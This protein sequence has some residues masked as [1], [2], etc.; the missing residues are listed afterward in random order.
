[1]FDFEP[2]RDSACG[3]SKTS[4]SLSI[5]TNRR[6]NGWTMFTGPWKI[7]N[8]DSETLPIFAPAKTA[9]LLA[10]AECSDVPGKEL[11]LLTAR[12]MCYSCLNRFHHLASPGCFWLWKLPRN[13]LVEGQGLMLFVGS[14]YE[15]S[16]AGVGR[17][18][19]CRTG[20]FRFFC[21]RSVV[22]QSS[23]EWCIHQP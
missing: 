16:G 11:P 10:S 23:L 4:S 20:G 13:N 22:P 5:I 3:G 21:G 12:S 15:T 1:M 9:W 18:Q 2:V 7:W 8:W 17:Y 19:I 14:K 6:L